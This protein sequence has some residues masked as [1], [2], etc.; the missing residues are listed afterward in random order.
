[1]LRMLASAGR[2]GDVFFFISHT[3]RTKVLVEAAGL[4]QE[5]EAKV[6]S[7]TAPGSPLAAR[8]DYTIELPDT[9]D[10]EQ[11]LPMTSRIVQLVILD[12]L[13]TGVTLQRG[14]KFLPHLA[15]IK[16]SVQATRFKD[17]ES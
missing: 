8:S 12:I 13:A 1:M 11:Y 4:A 15:R 9:E 10:T 5:T 6:I 2:S 7:L 3:G 17:G 16:Q 14:E